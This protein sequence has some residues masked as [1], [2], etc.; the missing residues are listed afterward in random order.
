MKL[1]PQPQNIFKKKI[2]LLTLNLHLKNVLITKS[3]ND[4]IEILEDTEFLIGIGITNNS[5]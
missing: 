5:K 3:F 4:I 1:L 2:T